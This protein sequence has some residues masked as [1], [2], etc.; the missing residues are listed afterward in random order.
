[1]SPPQPQSSQSGGG[2]AV[3]TPDQLR[4]WTEKLDAWLTSLRT[5]PDAREAFAFLQRLLRDNPADPLDT[6][7]VSVQALYDTFAAS[8]AAGDLAFFVERIVATHTAEEIERSRD[9]IVCLSRL[10]GEEAPGHILPLLAD[11]LK[12]L[13]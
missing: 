2:G 1:L 11:S 8:V 12:R 9:Y 10:Y 3:D 13:V 4:E 5:D 7:E 6:V